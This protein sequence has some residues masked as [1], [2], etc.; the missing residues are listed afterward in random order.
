MGFGH[1][2]FAESALDL[3]EK[4]VVHPAATFFMRRG[5]DILIVDRSLDPRPDDLIV[6]IEDGELKLRRFQREKPVE[7]W[8]VVTYEIRDVGAR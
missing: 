3:N 5:K 1:E 4:L 6:A 7:L 2:D 8:G